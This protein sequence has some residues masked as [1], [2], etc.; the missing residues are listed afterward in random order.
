ML[1]LCYR[2]SG[3]VRPVA[4]ANRKESQLRTLRSAP[5]E[6]SIQGWRRDLRGINCADPC[7]RGAALQPAEF[8]KARQPAKFCKARPRGKH[9]APVATSGIEPGHAT[10]RAAAAPRAPGRPVT[11]SVATLRSLNRPRT[12]PGEPRINAQPAAYTWDP[13][14]G[15]ACWQTWFLSSE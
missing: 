7:A 1:L 12:A 6:N 14:R 2:C 11:T 10:R 8:Y 15:A 4:P 5:G 9:P 13:C 3:G